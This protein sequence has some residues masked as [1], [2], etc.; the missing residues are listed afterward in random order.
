MD[1]G[2]PGPESCGFLRRRQAKCLMRPYATPPGQPTGECAGGAKQSSIASWQFFVGG[3]GEREAAG[4]C[5][6]VLE[7]RRWEFVS[8]F[9]TLLPLWNS[10]GAGDLVSTETRLD[11][12]AGS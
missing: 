6:Y 2:R 1:S 10:V 5:V 8:A 4:G 11:P 12:S 3:L 7:S 9:R